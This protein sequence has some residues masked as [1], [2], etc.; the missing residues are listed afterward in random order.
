MIRPLFLLRAPLESWISLQKARAGWNWTRTDTTALKPEVDPQA[1]AAWQDR[2]EEW[3]SSVL[4]A[5][6]A[7][8]R[9]PGVLRYENDLCHPQALQR[10]GAVLGGLLPEFNGDFGMVLSDRARQDQTAD[11]FER[12]ANGPDFKAWLV[13]EGRLERALQAGPGLVPQD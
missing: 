6:K 11:P 5:L 3:F 7:A 9:S 13:A 4:D 1:F 10:I 8:G 12:I 2:Q